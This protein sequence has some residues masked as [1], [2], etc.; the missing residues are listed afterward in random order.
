MS[1]FCAFGMCVNYQ[2]FVVF[3]ISK[4]N[5]CFKSQI[6]RLYI[7]SSAKR[8]RAE[9]KQ[10]R[11]QQLGGYQFYDDTPLQL[12]ISNPKLIKKLGH[13]SVYDLD[14][15]KQSFKFQFEFGNVYAVFLRYVLHC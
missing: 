14:I 3:Q 12:C 2:F 9:A 11:W 5:N 10:W 6:I 8:P 1:S 4:F 13:T 15:G 7:L